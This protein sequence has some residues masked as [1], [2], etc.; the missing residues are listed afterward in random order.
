MAKTKTRAYQ[1]KKKQDHDPAIDAM[2]LLEYA[3]DPKPREIARKFGIKYHTYVTRL[4][5]KLPD[6]RKQEY[7]EKAKDIQD[8][9]AERVAT[10]SFEFVDKT[11]SRLTAIMEQAMDEWEARFNDPDRRERIPERE[12]TNI[13]KLAQSFVIDNTNKAGEVEESTSTNALF[14]I[15]DQ[16][17]S[18]KLNSK[19]DDE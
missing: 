6:E 18:E 16:S 5:D 9:V 3:R 10:R 14:N 7:L 13:I 12:L 19:Q 1:P 15:M 4:W 8:E 11:A 2:I 17:I